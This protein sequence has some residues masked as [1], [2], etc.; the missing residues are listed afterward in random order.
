MTKGTNKKQISGVVTS[1]SMD[2]TISVIVERRLRHPIYG[3]YVKKTKKFMTHDEE[4]SCN[5]GD[6]VRIIESRPLSKK[7]RWAL[8]EILERAK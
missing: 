7:K 3:K 1:T 4:N 6:K 2:K 8:A 5:V